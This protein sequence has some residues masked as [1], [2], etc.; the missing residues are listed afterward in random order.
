MNPPLGPE[1]I[2]SANHDVSHLIEHYRTIAYQGCGGGGEMIDLAD[3]G[4]LTDLAKK[5]RNSDLNHPF[6]HSYLE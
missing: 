2:E 4:V 3:N 6:C 1:F 5:E